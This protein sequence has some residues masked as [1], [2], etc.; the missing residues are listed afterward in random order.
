MDYHLDKEDLV[1]SRDEMGFSKFLT[2]ED[3]AESHNYPIVVSY[4]LIDTQTKY[5]FLQEMSERETT[6]YF[7]IMQKFS[8]YTLNELIDER[9]REYH[10]YRTDIRGNLKKA[11]KDLTTI[12]Y[13]NNEL[14]FYHFAL[15]TDKDVIADRNTGEKSPRIYFIL[16]AYGTIYPVFYDPYHEL[17]PIK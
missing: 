7:R 17:N 6:A 8:S 3:I 5:N 14:M 16:G 11:I 1:A 10:L 9:R 2:N 12:D 4:K 15:Y 13:N